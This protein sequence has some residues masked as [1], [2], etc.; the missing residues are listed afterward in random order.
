L[1][2]NHAC[3][4]QSAPKSLL[5][6]VLFQVLWRSLAGD[7]GEWL[8]EKKWGKGEKKERRGMMRKRKG[9]GL[10]EKFAS[11]SVGALVCT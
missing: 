8:S 11:L 5:A 10:M 2:S 3:L 1:L 6:G 9:K 7:F 4:G